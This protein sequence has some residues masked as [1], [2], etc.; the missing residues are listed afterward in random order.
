[1]GTPMG[2]TTSANDSGDLSRQLLG[3]GIAFADRYV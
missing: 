3:S 2:S 1:M